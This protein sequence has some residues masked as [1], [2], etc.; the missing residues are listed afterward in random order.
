MAIRADHI[1]AQF[2][3]KLM[4]DLRGYGARATSYVG[5]IYLSGHPDLII[6][7]VHGATMFV[8]LKLFRL[9]QMPTRETMLA[10]LKG[11]QIN[12]ITKQLWLRNAPCLLVAEI[13]A[14]P[15]TL[16]IV[17]RHHLS[18]DTKHN[19]VK[20]MAHAPFGTCPYLTQ[21]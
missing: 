13:V 17:S 16:C 5:N 4:E 6:V 15:D 20:L 2:Q 21:G 10:L 11:P 12:V 14:K 7:S 18:F 1:E 8:E 3:D 19:F 9:V